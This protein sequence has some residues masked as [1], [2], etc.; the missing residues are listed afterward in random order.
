[1]RI[2]PALVAGLL[3]SGCGQGSGPSSSQSTSET[4][5]APAAA[6]DA[7]AAD[8]GATK[9]PVSIPQ[10]AYAYKLGYKL[11][12]DKMAETQDAHRGLCEAMGP[13]RCQLL[14]LE[15]VGGQDV[16]GDALLRVRVATSEAS[17][18][19]TALNKAVTDAGGRVTDTNVEGEDVSKSIVDAKARIAQ[20]EVLVGRLTDILR[21]RNG[22][23]EELVAAERSV[24]QAQEEL[25][26]A[27][28]WLTELQGRVA[29]SNF[30]IRYSA[31]APSTSAGS[32]GG[33]LGEATEGSA[34][35]FLIGLR[36]LFTLAIYLL[37]WLL[38][39]FPVI[40]LLRRLSRKQDTPPS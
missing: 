28:G 13:A 21:K 7:K 26:Q 40:W 25:D 9:V 31:S 1:M 18:F 27:R 15:R 38:L 39:L 8:G 10:L 4:A 37:P 16:T 2:L 34:A 14:A 22:K 19:Q 6:A 33:Q 29:M 23:V 36:G 30:E 5:E 12:S 3:V 32:V 35:T 17:V 11:P 24:A 20:R